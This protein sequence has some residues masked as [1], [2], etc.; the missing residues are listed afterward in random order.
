MD[1]LNCIVIEDQMPAQEILKSFI[2]QTPRLQLLRAF[3]SPLEALEMLDSLDVDIL[4]LDIDLP[5]LTGIELLRS[6]KSPPKTIITTAF[7]EYAL[8]GYELDVVD[9]LLK[10]FSFERFL[11]SIFKIRKEKNNSNSEI[12]NESIFVKNK[13]QIKK[14][15]INEIL[16][17]EAKGDFNIILTQSGKVTANIS[18]QKMLLTLPSNFI[19][20]HKSYI[21]NITF[22]EKIVGNQ[23]L[24]KDKKIPIGRSYKEDLIKRLKLI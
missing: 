4:F 17:V 11:K 23:I 14:I 9:Y 19:R 5:K 8:E 6:M 16:L 1:I 24:V 3:V 12:N 21:I 13:G 22:I 18:L 20:C 15:V 10:P 7:S 2:Q